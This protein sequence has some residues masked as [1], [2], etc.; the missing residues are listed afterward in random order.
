MLSCR[1]R[2]AAAA[3]VKARFRCAAGD[4]ASKRDAARAAKAAARNSPVAGWTSM[5]MGGRHGWRC[6]LG[7]FGFCSLGCREILVLATVLPPHRQRGN[8]STR[9]AEASRRAQSNRYHYSNDPSHGQTVAIKAEMWRDHPGM[10]QAED[11]VPRCV[12]GSASHHHWPAYACNAEQ[13]RHYRKR[14]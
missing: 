2:R 3:A 4:C 10:T 6:M 12:I 5:F 9:K 11:N 13:I 8:G 7:A 14:D 1:A